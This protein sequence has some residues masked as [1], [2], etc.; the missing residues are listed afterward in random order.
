MG[1]KVHPIGFRLGVIKDWQTRWYAEGEQYS[2]LLAEDRAIRDLVMKMNKEAGISFVEIERFPKEV[3]VTIHS[4]K[5]GIIIGRKGQNVNDLRKA[6]QDSTGKRVKV[7]VREIAKPDLDARLVAQ[8]LVEQ[9]ER[10]VSYK[11]ALKRA[12]GRALQAGAKG[13]MVTCAGRL[14]GSEMARRESAREGRVPR[15]T[16]RADI[17]YGYAEALTT[18]GRIGVKV[19][20]YQGEV[21]PEK[22]APEASYSA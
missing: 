9:L 10:R 5:P 18:F 22:A 19:W 15:H 14:A 11:R 7:D 16:V 4:A 13:A 2:A 8:S 12:V 1:R 17:D 20:I 6:L 3:S 21:L